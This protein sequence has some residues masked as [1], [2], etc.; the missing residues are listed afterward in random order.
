MDR[1]DA[2]YELDAAVVIALGSNL[3]GAYAS[4]EA[5]LDAAV[6]A[7]SGIGVRVRARSFWWRSSA[8][9]DATRPAFLNGVVLGETELAP[10][11]LLGALADMER[12]FGRLQGAV[13][14]PRTLDLDLIAHGRA[15]VNEPD[16]ILPH[17]RAYERKFVMGPLAEIAPEW[18]HPIGG[19]SAAQL[20]GEAPV[21]R[22]A[23]P[24]LRD[25]AALHNRPRNAI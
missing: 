2:I 10:P 21:G 11:A 24:C 8:W 5:L 6:G 4:S 16:L 3:A 22:D 13:N 15:V 9:P 14:A 7:L 25:H 19:K 12:E 1:R 23:T 20:A 18:R 17:P